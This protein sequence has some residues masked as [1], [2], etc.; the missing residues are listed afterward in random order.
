MVAYAEA[1]AEERF[2]AGYDLSEVQAAFNALK[3]I[4]M[5]ACRRDTR[6][7]RA[8]PDARPG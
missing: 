1:V 7:W 6:P 4:H 3:R 8:R 5:D 2:H